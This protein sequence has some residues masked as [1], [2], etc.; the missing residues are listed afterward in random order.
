M[1]VT[2]LV[3]STKRTIGG[4]IAL[5]EFANGLSRRGHGV[6]LVHLAIIDG[7]IDRIDDLAWFRFDPRIEH[8]LVESFDAIKLPRSDF[9]EVTALEFFSEGDATRDLPATA[10]LPFLFVQAYGIYPATVDA[11]AFR[12]PFPKIYIA[13]WLRRVLEEISVPPEQLEYVP[14]GLDHE[15]FRLTRPIADRPQQVAMLFNSHPIKGANFGLAA[16]EAAQRRIPELRAVL[17]GNKDSAVPMPRGVRYVKL[18]SRNVLVDEIYN[19]SRVFVCSSISEG[20]GFCSIEAMAGGCAVVTTDNG[21]SDDYAI[22]GETAL[23]CAPRDVEGMADRIERLLQDDD[24]C[25]RIAT[26]GHES[27]QRFDWDDSALR[28]EEFLN[29]YAARSNRRE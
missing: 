2:F 21:G 25:A 18:P 8:H 7:H 4:V 10:G 26:R 11:R 9:I 3:P 23:V 24:L 27:V 1:K 22:D 15:T 16:I 6:H 12:A 28:L 20:F 5:Y 17:F 19:G 14:Y 13:R 29:S